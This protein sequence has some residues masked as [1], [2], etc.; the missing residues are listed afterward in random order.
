MAGGPGYSNGL[1]IDGLSDDD[2]NAA[3]ANSGSDYR[4]PAENP[5]SSGGD[6]AGLVGQIVGGLTNRQQS[7]PP[8]TFQTSSTQA[9]STWQSNPVPQQQEQNRN[10][11]SKALGIVGSIYGGGTGAA[12]GT[13]SK[14]TAK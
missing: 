14:A 2:V 5:Q 8:P 13:A 11:L 3:L 1:S 12:L 6:T 9:P 4:L 10:L 7:A